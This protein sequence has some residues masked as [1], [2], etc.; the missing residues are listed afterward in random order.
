MENNR[1][2]TIYT[3]SSRKQTVLQAAPTDVHGLFERLGVSQALPVTHDAYM[4]LPKAKQDATKDIGAYIAG[5][6]QGGRRRNGCVLTRCAA[7]LDTDNLPPG[8]AEEFIK[9]VEGLGCCY[10]IHSTAK[11]SAASPRLR[12]VFPFAEDLPAEKYAPVARLLCQLIQLDMTWFDPSTD[13]AGRIM[14]Y[15]AHCQDIAPVLYMADKPFLDAAALLARLPDWHD[16]TAWPRFPREQAPAKAATKQEDPESKS[17]VVG[18]FCRVYDVPA[19]M[20]KFIPG[21]YEPT[22]ADDR[23]TFAAGSSWGGATV[24][25]GGKFLF[26]HHATDPAGGRLVNAFD[27]VRL[28]LF[29]GLDD[30]AKEGTRGNRLPSYGAMAALARQDP[31][32]SDVL[33]REAFAAATADFKVVE[34][35]V[36][37]AI[38][39]VR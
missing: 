32:V 37:A 24:Y 27:L 26:S 21:V 6:L 14:Y 30:E 13:E 20:E 25:E 9:R 2:L 33:A 38:E 4:A 19:A 31:A 35:D 18:A 12:A 3:A 23:Y 5:D 11:H 36:V 39:I 8:G 34:T 10:L 15:P 28:H 17:G 22:T 7:V 29:V 1:P 16:V